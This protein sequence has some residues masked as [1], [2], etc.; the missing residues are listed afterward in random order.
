MKTEKKVHLNA[1]LESP[2]SPIDLWKL[3]G[4]KTERVKGGA[5]PP[6]DSLLAVYKERLTYTFI[7]E[8]EVASIHFDRAKKEIFFKGHNINNLQLT[9]PQLAALEGLKTLLMQDNRGKPFLLDYQ[10]T[11]DRWLA[12]NR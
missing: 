7:M 4:G 3:M 8:R 10:A 11:L 12:D 5:M 1:G 6:S 9:Q 2:K